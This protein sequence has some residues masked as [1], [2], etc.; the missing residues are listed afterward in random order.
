M[1]IMAKFTGQASRVRCFAHILNLV[2]RLILRQFDIRKKTGDQLT[3]DE[4]KLKR[5][6]DELYQE[7]RRMDVGGLDAEGD[8]DDSLDEEELEVVD[9]AV[10]DALTDVAAEA[11]SVRRVLVKVRLLLRLSADDLTHSSSWPP[12]AS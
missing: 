1:K 4:K 8:R 7:E 3:E 10:K 2:I 12:I 6:A 11:D 5:L 9:D